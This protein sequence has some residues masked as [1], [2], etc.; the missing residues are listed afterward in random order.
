M[1]IHARVVETTYT[2]GRAVNEAAVCVVSVAV[3]V[4]ALF[5]ALALAL[6]LTAFTFNET[7]PRALQTEQQFLIESQR[8]RNTDSNRDKSTD[9]HSQAAAR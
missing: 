9:T 2:A 3:S 6:V 4:S 7:A 5:L 1:Q 8:A